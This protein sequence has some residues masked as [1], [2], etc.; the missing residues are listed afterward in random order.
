MKKSNWAFAAIM[1]V[2]SIAFATDNTTRANQA[3]LRQELIQLAQA[4]TDQ[5]AEVPLT[6]EQ[7]AEIQRKDFVDR[8]TELRDRDSDLDKQAIRITQEISVLESQLKQS[9]LETKRV[10]IDQKD[11]KRN[12]KELEREKNLFDKQD[13]RRKQ[14]DALRSGN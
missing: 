6:P 1:L 13:K 11:V 12:I 4:Q 3:A 2:A 14:M 9:K 7:N 8:L 5:A 10:K